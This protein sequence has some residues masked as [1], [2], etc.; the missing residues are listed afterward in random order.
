MAEIIGF[1]TWTKNEPQ[2]YLKLYPEYVRNNYP[3]SK[4]IAIVDDI[5]SQAVFNRTESQ[6]QSINITYEVMMRK[7]GFSSIILVSSLVQDDEV[8]K[9]VQQANELSVSQFLRLLPEKKRAIFDK[10]ALTETIDSCW[11]FAVLKMGVDQVGVNKYLTAKRSK[12]LFE[13]AKNLIDGL[14]YQ[15]IDDN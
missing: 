6:N 7:I 5:L 13:T 12:Y 9:Y 10:L 11:Q 8:S 4:L 2:E 15:I 14:E 3:D 1:N